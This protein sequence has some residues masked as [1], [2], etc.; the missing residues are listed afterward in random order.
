MKKD[1]RRVTFM[2][3]E[4]IYT[5]LR[6]LQAKTILKT[7]QGCSFSKSINSVL[8]EGLFK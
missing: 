8:R 6:K 2:I 3:D 4:Q 7:K 5:K 1:F